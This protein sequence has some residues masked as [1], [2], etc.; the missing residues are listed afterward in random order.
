[1]IAAQGPVVIGVI[2]G[3][4]SVAQ[5][6]DQVAETALAPVEVLG[7]SNRDKVVCLRSEHKDAAGMKDAQAKDGP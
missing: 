7:V 2:D 5:Q 4:Q 6:G 3:Q 1:M